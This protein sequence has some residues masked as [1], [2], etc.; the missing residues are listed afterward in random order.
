MRHA[1]SARSHDQRGAAALIVTVGLFFAMLLATLFANRNLLFEQRSAANQVRSTQAFEA[2]EAGLE[3]SIAQLNNARRI[4]PDC[5]PSADPTASSFRSRYLSVTRR[6]AAFAVRTWNASGTDTALQPTC[7]RVGSGWSCSCPA[8]GLPELAAP[9]GSTPASAFSLRFATIGKPGLVRIS[10]TGCSSLAGACLPGSTGRAEATATIDVT[11]GLL[12]AL[13][14][15][16][17]A[18]LTARGAVDADTATLGVHNPDPATGIAIHTG[19]HL[20][21]AQARLTTPAGAPKAGALVSDDA[22]LAGANADR[23][24]ASHFGVGKTGWKNQP[25]VTRLACSGDCTAALVA[26][27]DA[28]ADSA[29]VWI[30]GDLT[31]TGPITLGSLQRPVLIVVSGALRLDGAVALNGVVYSA[32]MNWSHTAGGAFLRGAAI[33]EG[34]YRGD[35]APELFYDTAVLDLLKGSAGTF[36]RVNGSWRDF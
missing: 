9:A 7:V 10:V 16:P 19:G 31:L 23:F 1:P 18:T 34:D 25:G 11:V 32:A 22:A 36:A 30:D 24:F 15:P 14:T 13:R 4:G 26:A 21:A 29:L 8:Q 3:W 5:Q 20:A 17:A 35:G 12:A 27:I 6:T 33:T 28:A 2:A